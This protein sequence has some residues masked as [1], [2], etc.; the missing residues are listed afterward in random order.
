MNSYTNE[1]ISKYFASKEISNGNKNRINK[2]H[3]ITFFAFHLVHMTNALSLHPWSTE[4]LPKI[5]NERERAID[6]KGKRKDRAA[7]TSSRGLRKSH[8]VLF[9]AQNLP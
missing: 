8:R 7:T 3:A 6:T 5:G 2:R 1:T 9:K 4:Q